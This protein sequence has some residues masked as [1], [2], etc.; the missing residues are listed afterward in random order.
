MADPTGPPTAAIASGAKPH[1]ACTKAKH[2]TDFLSMLHLSLVAWLGP[3]NY[4][5]PG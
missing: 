3:I 2:R 1:A 4:R 5:S